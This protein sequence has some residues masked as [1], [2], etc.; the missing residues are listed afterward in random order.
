MFNWTTPEQKRKI[1]NWRGRWR[2]GPV[3]SNNLQST[4]VVWKKLQVTVL[5]SFPNIWT[6]ILKCCNK[7]NTYPHFKK[8]LL[9]SAN[10]AENI[11][12][13][14][15]IEK[16]IE[17]VIA[18][19]FAN[20]FNEIKSEIKWFKVHFWMS[21]STNWND[22]EI[23]DFEFQLCVLCFFKMFLYLFSNNMN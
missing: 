10:S 9:L 3:E 4:F 20:I 21:C 2:W 13:I 22:L 6:C 1:N 15:N 12:K 18:R 23:W 16:K 17:T 7:K 8:L 19:N 14:Q 5:K 11:A